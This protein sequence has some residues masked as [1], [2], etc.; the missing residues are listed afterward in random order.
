MA[1][2][3]LYEPEIQYQTKDGR[4][5]TNGFLRVYLAATDDP[6]TTYSDFNGTVNQQ[7]IRLDDDGRAVV[8]VDN[9]KAYR[10]EVYDPEGTLLFTCSPVTAVGG[11]GGSGTN[12]VQV[13]SSDGTVSVSSSTSAGTRYFDLSVAIDD[14]KPSKWADRIGTATSI[15]GDG[16]WHELGNW[17]DIGTTVYLN[18]WQMATDAGYDVAG[19]LEMVSGD[20]DA[21]SSI[22]V[23]FLVTLDGVAQMEEFGR[24][25]PTKDKDRVSFEWK[26]EGLDHQVVN[27]RIFVRASEDMDVS[28]V[29]R[30][31][32]NE[33]VNGIVGNGSG[34]DYV[35]GDYIEIIDNLIQ[36]TGVQPL[37]GMS[38][39]AYESSLSSKLD[40]S[41]SGEFY[42]TSN[43]SG[44]VTGGPYVYESSYSS[45]SSEITDNISSISSIVSA[46]SG[47]TGDFVEKSSISA[48][49]AQWNEVSGLSSKLDSSASSGFYPTSNPSGFISSADAST[50]F[51]YNSAY[52]SFSSETTSNFSSLSSIVSAISGQTGDFVEK[53]SISAESAKW[54]EVSGMSGKVDETAMSAWIPYS[55][56]EGEGGKVTGVSGSAFKG[57][58]YT[59]INP[60]TVDNT[61]DT[62]SVEH[63]TLCVDSTMT[64]YNSGDS[65]VIGVN[66]AGLD[67]SSKMDA[68]A[69][70]LFYPADNPSGFIDG[71]SA[72]AVASAYAESAA[73]SKQDTL[74]F[75]YDDDKISAINGSALAGQ[76]GGGGSPIVVTGT[77]WDPDTSAYVYDLSSNLSAAQR[78]VYSSQLDGRYNYI[79]KFL[80]DSSNTYRLEAALIRAGAEQYAPG[81][82]SKFVYMPGV[83]MWSTADVATGVFSPLQ[84]ATGA[85][86]AMSAGSSFKA[87]YKGNEWFV[88]NT[89]YGMLR[90]E[91]HQSRGLRIVASSTNSASGFQ[92]HPSGVNGVDKNGSAW[93]YGPS[94]NNN[95]SSVYDTVSANSASWGQGGVDSATVS[96]I[97]SSYAESATSGKVD[98][99]AYDDLYSAF[100]ALS[101]VISTYSAYFSGISAKVDNS[102]IGVTE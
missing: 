61:A 87:Y 86:L 51:V 96:A 36:A 31:C 94:E 101:G 79:D 88:S 38:A 14:N 102:A 47:Q 71:A 42:P 13:I 34:G 66:V 16:E 82:S 72:S 64:A 85:C 33:E 2:A 76:G 11:G 7:D 81:W 35:A 54:N 49:S 41:A 12:F 69:S 37:S 74:S 57:H 59:G 19:S 77:A 21:L 1:F 84:Y 6:A 5:N 99:S 70:S 68:S 55:A 80:D 28:L 4:N 63:R 58:E 17:V 18:G 39:Y 23:R 97:A 30:A 15:T 92:L 26:Q 25:D 29:S 75:D 40:A 44:F 20:A 43:P 98:Q 65:A 45:F 56:L 52:S 100:T 50:S 9:S 22:D 95:L 53:S 46:I 3:Y 48:E 62:I 8:I 93:K 83:S 90:G 60:V 10:L 89:Q 32:Y 73:S 67:I 78:H 24:I 27:A 91:I